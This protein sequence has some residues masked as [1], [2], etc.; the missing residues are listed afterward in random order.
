VHSGGMQ[1]GLALTCSSMCDLMQKYFF[2]CSN[3]INLGKERFKEGYFCGA[4]HLAQESVSDRLLE[5]SFVTFAQSKVQ[6][7]RAYL[8]P[9]ELVG[10]VGVCDGLCVAIADKGVF[11]F[12]L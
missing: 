3:S 6:E 7:P 5:I 2:E 9:V 11:D 10:L 1:T 8:Y 4:N 12:F